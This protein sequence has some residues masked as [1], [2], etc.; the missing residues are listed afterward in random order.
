MARLNEESLRLLIGRIK[1]YAIFMLDPDGIVISWN[2]GAQRLKGYSP[3]EI[4]GRSFEVFYGEDD[5]KQGRPRHLLSVARSDGRVEDEGWRYRKDG[6]RFW[7]DVV[8]TALRDGSGNLVG[9]GKVTRDLTERRRQEQAISELS[10]RLLRIQDD[11]RRRIA[12]ELHDTTSPLLTGLI[13]KLYTLRKVAKKADLEAL[14]LVDE[15][16]AMAEATSTMVRTMSALLHPS[17]LDEGGLLAT[18]RWYLDAYSS[19]TGMRITPRLPQSMPRQTRE[20][21]LALFRIAQEWLDNFMQSSQA[22]TRVSLEMDGGEIRLELAAG[23]IPADQ[24]GQIREGEGEAGVTFM[25][26]RER[27]R[28]LGGKFELIDGADSTVVRATLPQHDRGRA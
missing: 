24:L 20:I 16:L 28:Q 7:A 10:G 19:R 11:E 3:Q 12:R 15:S 22:S 25:A 6:S 17:L 21:E 9:Y 14:S 23:G 26:S 4:I 27:L 1:D 2:E 5:V 8:I 13:S 18:L